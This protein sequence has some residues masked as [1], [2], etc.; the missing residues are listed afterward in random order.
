[1]MM[2]IHPGQTQFLFLTIL[3]ATLPFIAHLALTRLFRGFL[4]PVRRQTGV[5]VA[6]LAGLVFLALALTFL[7]SFKSG[8]SSWYA[9]E[10]IY[11]LSVYLAAA[12]VYFHFF[13]MSETARRI[14]ILVSAG[15]D[16]NLPP[17]ESVEHDQI[18]LM[19]HNRLDRLVALKELTSHNSL[20]RIGR[21]WLLIPAQAAAMF[22][23]LIFPEATTGAPP[24]P[25]IKVLVLVAVATGLGAAWSEGLI[26]SPATPSGKLYLSLL[27]GIIGAGAFGLISSRPCLKNYLL[28]S[29]PLV[30]VTFEFV[31]SDTIPMGDSYYYHF[32][33]FQFVAESIASGFW[34][35][36]WLPIEGGVDI[37][38]YH[39]N[40]FPFLP[41]R[42]AGYTIFAIFP[43]AAATAYK[44]Q[45]VI[46]VL[47]CAWGW[48]AVV[49]EITGS[50]HAAFWG[51]ICIML[52]GTGV[53]FH[54]EQVIAT[55]H[56]L[57]WFTLCLLKMRTRAAW[58]L[59][60]TAL[61]SLGLST[62]YPQIQ[63]I[64]M[65]LVAVAILSWHRPRPS[66]AYQKVK[67]YLPLLPLLF[68]MGALPSLNLWYHSS[69]LAGAKR[70]MDHLRPTSYD[71]YAMMMG[72]QSCGA[73]GW[74]F[75][76]YLFPEF[77]ENTE[78]IDANG[79]FVGR[80]TLLLALI[81]IVARPAAAIPITL[82][83]V[84]FSELTMG[85]NSHLALPRLLYE[86]KFPFIDVFRQWYH[87]FPLIN[88]TLSLLAAIGLCKIIAIS[89]IHHKS[90]LR[91]AIITLTIINIT[92]LTYNDLSYL[93][94]IG[95]SPQ[96]PNVQSRLTEKINYDTSLFQYKDRFNLI[97]ECS[98][99]IPTSAFTTTDYIITPGGPDA[100]RKLACVNYKNNITVVNHAD[101][102]TINAVTPHTAGVETTIYP[103]GTT[104]KTNAP[105]ES[106][107]T[108]PVNYSLKTKAFV[109]GQA[110]PTRRVN[111]T[112][113]GIMLTKGE[114]EICVKK[115]NYIYSTIVSA[116]W[117][118]YLFAGISIALLLLRD[119]TSPETSMLRH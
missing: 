81:A 71:E 85:D 116:Q 73:Q 115:E 68:I 105:S 54:Q 75:G 79:L 110:A 41:S 70:G 1:M 52:G 42:L 113:N 65:G 53:T 17:P 14:R 97:K 43:V 69:E 18:E 49:S 57:P 80:I 22:R 35:P 67:S 5:G 64:S 78:R 93:N 29:L 36:T 92:D 26:A 21:G 95:N 100:E 99:A 16:G 102:S 76:Q 51:A 15:D 38:Y 114:H 89:K 6:S 12:Y 74:Y 8:P 77:Y 25:W 82:L 48:Y 62:H 46:G 101:A 33:F 23:R 90:Y 106:L 109:D 86:I 66:G 31:A 27:G 60:A 24:T 9:A 111:S 72:S 19:I 45:L 2:S 50:E 20:Y 119:N 61:F 32:P 44:M 3:C 84:I 30:F 117:A 91:Y 11:L 10:I 39:I 94:V 107:L 58:I 88:F 96:P 13:N 108:T 112:L 7:A 63:T 104:Y 56:L 83:L 87:F 103:W 118:L 37:S 4:A 40:N 98:D 55:T 59:P 34:I 47:F 28:V